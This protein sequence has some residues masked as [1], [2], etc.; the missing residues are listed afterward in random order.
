MGDWT[1]GLL[2]SGSEFVEATTDMWASLPYEEEAA[3]VA[4]AVPKRRREFAAGRACARSAMARLGL[5]EFPVVPDSRRVPIWP[6][7][8]VG[9]ITHCGGF[10][11]AVAARS[12]QVL[13]IG[14]DVELD[15]PLPDGVVETT[16]SPRELR[17]LPQTGG[18][19]WATLL[20]S[21]K[22]AVY[23]AWYPLTRRRLGFRDIDINFDP[24]CGTF[25]IRSLEPR[26]EE[27]AIHVDDLR[28]TFASRSGL[29]FTAAWRESAHAAA[30]K[31]RW[32]DRRW[33][34]R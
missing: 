5:P 13:A 21:A 29:L 18:M 15:V 14:I 31:P 27:Q 26:V 25:T 19:N 34:T 20:F 32:I 8:V 17:D 12:A 22:E 11:A 1:K 4:H 23:K 10:C 9:S 24:W 28:G 7:G 33:S 6:P 30:L 3:V 2:P 16:C